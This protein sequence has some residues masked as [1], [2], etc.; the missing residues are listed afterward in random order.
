MMDDVKPWWDEIR[1]MT[2]EEQQL[3]LI[4]VLIM[5]AHYAR[6][7]GMSDAEILSL[8]W[9]RY[10]K[11]LRELGVS[12]EEFKEHVLHGKFVIEE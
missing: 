9:A 8:Y 6:K 7:D 10:Q 5:A 12:K 11:R 2:D 3:E 4:G 1:E